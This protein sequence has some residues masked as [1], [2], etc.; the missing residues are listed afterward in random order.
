MIPDL[1]YKKREI[2]NPKLQISKFKQ[3]NKYVHRTNQKYEHIYKMI[4]LEG[5]VP[6]GLCS[7]S[8][9]GCLFLV[10]GCWVLIFGTYLLFDACSLEFSDKVCLSLAFRLRSRLQLQVPSQ[11][12]E[13]IRVKLT[14]I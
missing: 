13:L 10:F 5:L 7:C 2:T 4:I 9:Y 11:V 3:K 1:F 8:L 14:N 12:E 6:S